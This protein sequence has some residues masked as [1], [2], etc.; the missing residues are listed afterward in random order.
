MAAGPLAEQEDPDRTIRRLEKRLRKSEM[1]RQ[2][3]EHLMDA[4]HAFQRR[5][6]EDIEQARAELERVNGALTEEK[7]LTDQLM[8]SIMPDHIA[9][10]LK[11][12]GRVQPR[13]AASATVMFADFVDFTETTERLDPVDLVGL[14]DDYYA[15][16]DA[17]IAECGVE[18]VKTIGDAYMC[19][20]GLEPGQEDHAARMRDAARAILQAVRD[21][22]RAARRAGATAWDV[23]IGL[24]SGPLSS[25]V[26]GRDRLSYDIWGDTVNTAARV[27]KACAVDAILMSDGTRRLLADS[28]GISPLGQVEAKGKGAVPVYALET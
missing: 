27:V 28:S 23:R 17:I 9:E 18:K 14:L 11:R 16:F 5:V 12:T 21:R 6:M 3:L 4:S 1:R 26:V 10:E 24:N 22:K 25:G 8:T 15:R 19:V 2:E 13:R 20:S 7:A